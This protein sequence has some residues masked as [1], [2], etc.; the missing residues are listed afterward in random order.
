MQY[1]QQ[2][3]QIALK[4]SD[5][6]HIIINFQFLWSILATLAIVVRAS[7]KQSPGHFVIM[8]GADAGCAQIHVG[9]A[10]EASRS[11]WVALW[12][13]GVMTEKCHG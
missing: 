5:D 2:N 10:E 11:A 6:S 1:V 12:S 3:Q 9:A 13:D 7:V 4:I 8:A